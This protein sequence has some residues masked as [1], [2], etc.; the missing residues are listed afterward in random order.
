MTKLQNNNK[1]EKQQ[2]TRT[3][4][5]TRTTKSIVTKR[6]KSIYQVTKHMREVADGAYSLLLFVEKRRR[7]L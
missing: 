4:E 1:I 2:K 6:G 5:R 7:W 3:A